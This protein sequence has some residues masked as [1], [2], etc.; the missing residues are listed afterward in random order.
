MP[1]RRRRDEA[2][3]PGKDARDDDDAEQDARDYVHSPDQFE[4]PD[5]GVGT[6]TQEGR[7]AE[8]E[9]AGQAEEDVEPDGEDA[10]DHEALHQ[11]GVA[12]VELRQPGMPGRERV[13]EER[14]QHRQSGR[15]SAAG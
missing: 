13:Q 9:I 5:A 7:V 1:E 4:H 11:V 2:D 10:E 14:G 6:D 15:R 12:R 8:A 3:E